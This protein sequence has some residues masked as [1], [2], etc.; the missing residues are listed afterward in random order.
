MIPSFFSKLPIPEKLPAEMERHVAAL[1]RTKGRRECLEQAYRIITSRYEGRKLETYLKLPRA[2][3]KRLE[4]IWTRTGYLH[5]HQQNYLLRVL[6]VKSG[7]FSEEDVR[8]KLTL[9]VISPHQ[10]LQVNLGT[11]SKPD[12]IDV[13]P[14][15]LKPCGLRIGKHAGR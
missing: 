1:Q 6:L 14:W 10:Y 11:K 5:C 9:Y 13:D 7:K 8:Q 2:F 12:W 15:A 4:K 3:T